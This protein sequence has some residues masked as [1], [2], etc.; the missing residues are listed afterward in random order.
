MSSIA[1]RVERV[2]QIVPLATTRRQGGRGVH[3]TVGVCRRAGLLARAEG[4]QW[5]KA[6]TVGRRRR[7]TEETGKVA[8]TIQL[9]FPRPNADRQDLG[10]AT[11]AAN[12]GLGGDAQLERDLQ[13]I[14]YLE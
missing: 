2:L 11:C 10:D 12:A 13:T 9:V 4:A 7:R 14:I 5:P 6:G 8:L 3:L 1:Q